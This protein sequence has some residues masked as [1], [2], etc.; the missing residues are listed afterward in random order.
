MALAAYRPLA[1]DR[2]RCRP[3]EYRRPSRIGLTNLDRLDQ[4]LLV[5]EHYGPPGQREVAA[6]SNDGRDADGSA[7]SPA[8]PSSAWPKHCRPV[9]VPDRRHHY[10]VTKSGLG[11][12]IPP[13][14]SRLTADS[15]SWNNNPGTN[16]VHRCSHSG[17]NG[18]RPLFSADH[19][20]RAP[21]ATRMTRDVGP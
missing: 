20:T 10:L 16:R 9:S 8:Q 19:S 21:H 2:R 18:L 7:V 3:P 14:C 4:F 17:L 1:S 11:A 6:N 5:E 13:A 12:G 15:P